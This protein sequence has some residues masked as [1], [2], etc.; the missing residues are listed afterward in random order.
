M[1]VSEESTIPIWLRYL[2]DE[3]FLCNAH[4]NTKTTNFDTLLLAEWSTILEKLEKI[5]DNRKILVYPGSLDLWDEPILQAICQDSRTSGILCDLLPD[6]LN[7]RTW[8]QANAIIG[9]RWTTIPALPSLI[10]ANPNK[11]GDESILLWDSSEHIVGNEPEKEPLEYHPMEW[12]ANQCAHIRNTKLSVIDISDK[13]LDY[14]K[15]QQTISQANQTLIWDC[16]PAVVTM[17]RSLSSSVYLTEHQAT[18]TSKTRQLSSV[19]NSDYVVTGSIAP[20]RIR[21]FAMCIDSFLSKARHERTLETCREV[22][23]TVSKE[24][25]HSALIDKTFRTLPNIPNVQKIKTVFIALIQVNLRREQADQLTQSVVRNTLLNSFLELDPTTDWINA[26]DWANANI[27]NW[28]NQCIHAAN[29]DTNKRTAIAMGLYRGVAREHGHEWRNGVVHQ[30]ISL[31]DSDP[32]QQDPKNLSWVA[33]MRI[34]YVGEFDSDSISSFD[35]AP[36]VVAAANLIYRQAWQGDQRNKPALVAK[37]QLIS[38]WVKDLTETQQSVNMLHIAAVSEVISGRLE[39][40]I[41]WVEKS[42]SMHSTVMADYCLLAIHAW[43]SGDTNLASRLLEMEDYQTGHH[44]IQQL[45]YLACAHAIFG[46]TNLASALF[47]GLEKY[48]DTLFAEV[49]HPSFRWALMRAACLALGQ[50]DQA[51]KFESPGQ[52]LHPHGQVLQVRFSSVRPRDKCTIPEFAKPSALHT[53]CR[54]PNKEGTH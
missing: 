52:E 42:R 1:V 32:Q 45:A 22:A 10:K 46:D 15:F 37:A 21:K 28:T 27:P 12:I 44:Q 13:C 4:K 54:K 30:A 7:Y 14:G 51:K 2:K 38:H 29:G 9:D 17:I 35:H 25:V 19:K 48:K 16:H 20:L 50:D 31:L 11:L 43:L 36:S 5:P 53:F 8:S 23:T 3:A 26:Y 39:E 24:R 40:A 18:K 33:A 6:E 34:A 47:N 49:P 41:A